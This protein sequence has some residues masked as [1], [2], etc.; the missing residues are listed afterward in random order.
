MASHLEDV[1][2]KNGK[3]KQTGQFNEYRGKS[4]DGRKTGT[5]AFY[6]ADGETVWHQI[7]YKDGRRCREDGHLLGLCLDCDKPVDLCLSAGDA[8]L[9]E[10]RVFH[11][12]APNLSQRT[13]KVVI[14]GYS[15]RWMGGLRDNMNLVQPGPNR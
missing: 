14:M 13:S 3:R 11:A 4:T 6:A 8:F 7:T 15:Y 5:W 2:R 12:T 9:F 10:N 1:E